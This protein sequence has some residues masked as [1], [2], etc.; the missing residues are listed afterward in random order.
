MQP[1]EIG[2]P[3]TDPN[4]PGVDVSG[5]G[6]GCDQVSGGFTIVDIQSSARPDGGLSSVTSLTAAFEPHCEVRLGVKLRMRSLHVII[7][8]GE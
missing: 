1:A 4:R 6:T 2:P 3:T 7:G 8:C 5:D